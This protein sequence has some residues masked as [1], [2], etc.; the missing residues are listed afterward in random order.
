MTFASIK[1]QFTRSWFGGAALGLV[2]RE[3]G[4]YVTGGVHETPRNVDV[5]GLW[6]GLSLSV[7]FQA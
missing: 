3:T 7:G 5:F 6:R 2:K 4:Y 1:A